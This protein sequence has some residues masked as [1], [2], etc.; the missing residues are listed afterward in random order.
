[1]ALGL[2]L[3]PR[4]DVSADDQQA[5]LAVLVGDP[6]QVELEPLTGAD[7]QLEVL[8][9]VERRGQ[10]DAELLADLG[11]QPGAH[12][13]P[14]EL[15]EV[16]E[17]GEVA[18]DVLAT[19]ADPAQVA[20][21][22]ADH[23]G[24]QQLEQ[25][26]VDLALAGERLECRLR[27]RLGRGQ[28][29]EAGQVVVSTAQCRRGDGE[30][31]RRADLGVGPPGLGTQVPAQRLDGEAL[32]RRGRR[33]RTDRASLIGPF[34]QQQVE[35]SSHRLLSRPAEEALGAGVE[36]RDGAGHVGGDD[37]VLDGRLQDPL[38]MGPGRL[39]RR[40]VHQG[41]GAHPGHPARQ[42]PHQRAHRDVE[43]GLSPVGQRVVGVVQEHQR[44]EHEGGD[45][46]DRDP[47]LPQR[48]VQRQPEDRQREHDVEVRGR[49]AVGV[50]PERDDR[51]RDVRRHHRGQHPVPGPDA[52]EGEQDHHQERERRHRAPSRAR[53]VAQRPAEEQL[54]QD[55]DRQERPGASRSRS[56]SWI[57][58]RFPLV[59]DA[60]SRSCDDPTSRSPVG[61]ARKRG[62][63]A[64]GVAAMMEAFREVGGMNLASGFQL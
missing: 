39:G 28:E 20:V 12:L 1:M 5:G 44:Q 34:G 30:V 58:H 57:P 4:A 8:G 40:G 23:R 50:T 36:H 24:R 10:G 52:D 29:D 61:C 16:G 33:R 35:V 6:G 37:G 14:L 17:V 59:V 42:R 18:A 47:E 22:D 55:E 31:H 11:R 49:P 19:D 26:A 2:G 64:P 48:A 7:R 54:G 27:V 38:E 32:V 41:L 15:G 60:R 51:D 56:T 13:L 45:R 43:E 25:V 62:G 21:E 3:V 53:Q 63:S 46:P 9:L